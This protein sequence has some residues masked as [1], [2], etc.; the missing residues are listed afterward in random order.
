M[1]TTILG[2][3][4]QKLNHQKGHLES[5]QNKDV[6]STAKYV[7]I[8]VLGSFTSISMKIQLCN[9]IYLD[10]YCIIDNFDIFKGTD[11]LVFYSPYLQ[12]YLSYLDVLGIILKLKKPSLM[13]NSAR[14]ILSVC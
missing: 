9:Y 12:N 2:K 5:K 13:V 10:K 8:I 14:S 3:N 1:E 7:H 6:F 4:F 11:Y